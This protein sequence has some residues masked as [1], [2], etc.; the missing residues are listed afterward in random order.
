MTN[1]PL[2]SSP[3]SFIRVGVE[4]SRRQGRDHLISTADCQ[5]CWTFGNLS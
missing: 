2:T 5:L 3:R 1:H 4:T